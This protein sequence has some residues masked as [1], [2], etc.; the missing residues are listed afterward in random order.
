MKDTIMAALGEQL[1]IK[2]KKR[3][4]QREGKFTDTVSHNM[5]L[6]NDELL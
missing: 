4:Y 2:G 3:K 5:S 6:K 1:D